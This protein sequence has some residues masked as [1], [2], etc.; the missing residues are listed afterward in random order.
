[1]FSKIELHSGYHRIRVK[2]GDIPKTAFITRYGH[3]EYFVMLFCVSNVPGEFMKYMN[4]IFYPYL[5]QFV[6]V[7][8]NDVLIYSMSDEEHVEHLRV[9]L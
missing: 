8:I 6:V 4:R 7:F 2:S 9:V 5:D 3:Y 1:M